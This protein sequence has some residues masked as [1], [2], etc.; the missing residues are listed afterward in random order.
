[1]GAHRRITERDG[2]HLRRTARCIAWPLSKRPG[3]CRQKQNHGGHGAHRGNK[4]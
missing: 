3:R 4:S 1:V 2:G